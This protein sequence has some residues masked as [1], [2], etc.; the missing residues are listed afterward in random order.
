MVLAVNVMDN[1]IIVKITNFAK[2]MSIVGICTLGVCPAFAM[3]GLVVG[4]VFK[5]KGVTVEGQCAK[6]IK[7]A[8][9]LGI[10]ALVLFVV[11]IVLLLCFSK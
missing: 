3:M 4:I 5:I 10:I 11:D 1:E 6:N 2:I 9:I 7:I 8:N